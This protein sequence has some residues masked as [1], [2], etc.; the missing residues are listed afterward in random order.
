[1]CKKDAI[2]PHG[3]LKKKNVQGWRSEREEKKAK[4]YM[5]IL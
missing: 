1:M 5:I 2:S 3:D 4:L